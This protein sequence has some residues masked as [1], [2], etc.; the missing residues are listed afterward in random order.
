MKEKRQPK[1]SRDELRSLLLETGRSILVEEGL[2]TGADALTFKRVF[3]RVEKES[4]IRLTNA[5][6]IRRVWENQADYQADVLATI[7]TDEERAEVAD[8]LEALHMMFEGV[9]LSVPETRARAMREVCRIGGAE[10]M[11]A[12]GRSKN[13]SLW[14]GVWAL[15]TAED[16]LGDQKRI[17][18]AL[19]E[20]YDAVTELWEGAYGLLADIL[21]LQL[22]EPLTMR[23]FTIAVGALAEGCSLRHRVDDQM[24]GVLLPTGP[25]GEAEEWTIFA[26]GLEALLRQFF[27]LDPDWSPGST[28]EGS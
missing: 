7:A 16:Q 5:S 19:M 21:G 10:N 15:G 26:V 23:Q 8:T 20:G 27:E 14:M 12:L 22:R 17:R 4:G 1:Q 2:G 25:D 13:W 11:L 24:K 9:D 3:K 28:A 6:I 18:A